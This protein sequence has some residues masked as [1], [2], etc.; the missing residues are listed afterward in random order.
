MFK[1]I[2]KLLLNYLSKL[3]VEQ[4]EVVGV[5]ISPS[6][7]RIAQLESSKKKWTLTKLGY[8]YIDGVSLN[9]ITDN[10]DLY[11]NKLS[12]LLSSNKIK[13]KSA[14]VSIPVSSAIIKVIHLPLMTDEE[15]KEAVATDSLWEN[16]GQLPE[17][18]QEYSIFWQVLKREPSENQM[19]ILFV[20]SKLD[21]IDYYLNI[22][23][24]AGL[25][26]VVVDVRCFATR[27]ALTLRSDLTK[28]DSTVAIVEFGAFENY[29][30]IL[31]EDSPFISDIY[32]SE[33]DRNSIL[34]NDVSEESL[35]AISG[36]FAMQVLQMISSYQT[37]YKVNPIES[38]LISSTMPV[39]DRILLHLNEAMPSISVEVFNPLMSVTV[40][41]NL[42]EK[43]NAEL[44][45]SIFSSALGLATRK[46]DVFGYYEYVTGTNNINL[47]PN[48]ENIKTQEKLKFLSRW[49]VVI[50]VIVTISLGA[51][52][53]LINKDEVKRIDRLLI[54]YNSLIFDKNEKQI[55]L[56]NLI[57][58]KKVLSGTLK[59]TENM[60]SNQEF[61]YSVLEGINNSIPNQ[62]LKLSKI[63]FENTLEVTIYG[64]TTSD[65]NI[66]SFIDNLS[67]VQSIDKA[68]LV[69]MSVEIILE[70]SAKSFTISCTLIKQNTINS[71]EKANGN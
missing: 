9:S 47:L 26:P 24:Q 71:K 13:T 12:Q 57:N 54:Q 58:K 29:I 67:N 38:V 53:F 22:V 2:L 3:T 25:N 35:K 44:N 48:R 39:I 28:T 30:L 19:H 8:K 63:D 18:L 45:N 16:A 65:N 32:L 33:K 34:D 51:W 60:T 46:L 66:L 21:D 10:P 52:S 68:S 42:S 36:R 50:F 59:A 55:I 61:M 1:K 7:I 15:L 64:L 40:P 43:S 14:A 27:N 31:H 49:G 62:Y 37:K 20:A 69:T 70:Q 41:E 17:D 56:D 11:V 4:E 5:D 6:C 23:R